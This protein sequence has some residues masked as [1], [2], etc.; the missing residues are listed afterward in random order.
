MQPVDPGMAEEASLEQLAAKFSDSDEEIVSV[1]KTSAQPTSL[2]PGEPAAAA[3]S[4]ARAA[5]SEA[6]DSDAFP[7]EDDD[8]DYFDSED[9]ELGS[10]LD[11]ADFSEE[12][13]A[14]GGAASTSGSALGGYH[15]NAGGGAANRAQRAA[16]QPTANN[17]QRLLA[18]VNTGAVTLRDDVREQ[19]GRHAGSVP[20]SVATAVRHKTS[21]KAAG[22]WWETPASSGTASPTREKW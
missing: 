11:W 13:G 4:L 10:A 22:M 9:E 7:V 18:R 15:P 3:D 14:R 21:G 12:M 1:V 19:F 8:D 17:M 5:T 16:L 2:Q 6:S 20:S